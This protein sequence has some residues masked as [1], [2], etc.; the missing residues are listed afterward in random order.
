[1]TINMLNKAKK[2]YLKRGGGVTV[3]KSNN[4][5]GAGRLLEFRMLNLK[6]WCLSTDYHF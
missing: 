4:K 5:N 3:V 1:M 2:K 6:I